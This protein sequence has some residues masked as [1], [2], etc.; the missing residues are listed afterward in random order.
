MATKMI[1]T[2]TKSKTSDDKKAAS[3]GTY[4]SKNGSKSG[5]IKADKTLTEAWKLISKRKKD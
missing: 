1:K 4:A 5:A 2:T 3:N